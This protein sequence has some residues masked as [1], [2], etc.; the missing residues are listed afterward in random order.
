MP[1]RLYDAA[2]RGDAAAVAEFLR[3]GDDAN[4]G[5]GGWAP[6]E[7]AAKNGHAGAV[8]ALLV[9]GADANAADDDGFRALAAT[10]RVH[11]RVP[12]CKNECTRA[13]E[14]CKAFN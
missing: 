8:E 3:E 4:E 10:A 2:N 13:L 6:L 12:A 5:S 9:G 1:P 7:R 14:T 11:A